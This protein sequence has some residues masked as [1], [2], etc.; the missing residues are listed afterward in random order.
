MRYWKSISSQRNFKKTDAN[1]IHSFEAKY[2]LN[3]VPK[4]FTKAPVAIVSCELGNTFTLCC[5][6]IQLNISFDIQSNLSFDIDAALDAIQTIKSDIHTQ[7]ESKNLLHLESAFHE[8]ADIEFERLYFSYKAN[9]ALAPQTKS[10]PRTSISSLKTL[11]DEY[12]HKNP[13]VDMGMLLHVANEFHKDKNFSD[14]NEAQE[15]LEK[16]LSSLESLE[17]QFLE[18]NSELNFFKSWVR[19][20]E[21]A[22]ILFQAFNELKISNDFYKIRNLFYQIYYSESLPT[23]LTL[24]SLKDLFPRLNSA[25]LYP[26]P[27]KFL[28]NVINASDAI[29]ERD[30]LIGNETSF[31]QYQIAIPD[32]EQENHDFLDALKAQY[33]HYVQIGNIAHF[34]ALCDLSRHFSLKNNFKNELAQLD[35]KDLLTFLTTQHITVTDNNHITSTIP[36]L[37]YAIQNNNLELARLIVEQLPLS[38]AIPL[39]I[40]TNESTT[41]I[42]P[43][44]TLIFSQAA[45]KSATGTS[46]PDLTII[47]L[48]K[49]I[50]K[51]DYQYQL[52]LFKKVFVKYISLAQEKL[53]LAQKDPSTN[54]DHNTLSSIL[55]ILQ[56]YL[57]KNH[58]QLPSSSKSESIQPYSKSQFLF[59]TRKNLLIE[60]NI[61]QKM[62]HSYLIKIEDVDSLLLIQGLAI[63]G[64]EEKFK[65]KHYPMLFKVA[66]DEKDIFMLNYLLQKTVLGENAFL[67][68]LLS[69]EDYKQWLI[70]LEMKERC[71]LQQWLPL[72]KLRQEVMN[73]TL[74]EF[75]YYY[76]EKDQNYND[77]KVEMNK[78]VI[79]VRS[80][81]KQN[82]SL[83]TLANLPSENFKPGLTTFKI[84]FRNYEHAIDTLKLMEEHPSLVF[85]FTN[86]VPMHQEHLEVINK[87]SFLLSN[88]NN[89]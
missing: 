57:D 16:F 84:H 87:P 38:I 21:N 4:A 25:S 17:Q 31:T 30:L 19:L 9:Q 68:S 65:T 71:K 89:L 67:F 20:P 1:Y 40:Q 66:Y 14:R 60:K 33:L 15:C 86:S 77:L 22:N 47:Y 27:L 44:E 23:V 82:A 48:I 70:F 11:E 45:V 83:E 76:F 37:I 46:N 12:Q 85:L 41:I 13:S 58:I 79:D 63:Y 18:N 24:Y 72:E 36:V 8:I 69:Q 54:I 80:F 2:R 29:R 5:E 32:T 42:Y 49:L 55:K 26:I 6:L 43:L 81:I 62:L 51:I 59:F 52:E 61:F 28:F 3:I 56:E 34:K 64:N 39:Q 10:E 7:L 50:L 53:D 35:C 75:C 74:D 78:F 88:N 73:L